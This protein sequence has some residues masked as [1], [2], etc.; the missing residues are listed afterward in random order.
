MNADDACC[1]RDITTSAIT[2]GGIRFEARTGSGDRDGIR[3]DRQTPTGS[4][5]GRAA[6]NLCAA[7]QKET[8]RRDA[9]I[10]GI[11]GHRRLTAP[12]VPPPASPPPP[13]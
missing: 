7:T 9:D 8:V 6:I 12:P 3:V 10:A 11:A 13:P 5:C 4:R 1:K 2:T